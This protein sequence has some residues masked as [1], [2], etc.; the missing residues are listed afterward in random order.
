M[1][2]IPGWGMA[3]HSSILAWEIPWTEKP[4]RLQPMG[5]QRV[6]DDWAT[7]TFTFIVKSFILITSLKVYQIQS[8][9]EIWRLRL[10]Q[11]N[12]GTQFSLWPSSP[13]E[14]TIHRRKPWK[15]ATGCAKVASGCTEWQPIRAGAAE[16]SRIPGWPRTH[17]APATAGKASSQL[18]I[19]EF[20][21]LTPTLW[22]LSRCSK[23][24]ST[25]S[26]MVIWGGGSWG[27][28]CTLQGCER[29]D[30]ASCLALRRAWE[31]HQ[32]GR[33]DSCGWVGDELG[34]VGNSESN[35]LLFPPPSPP[36]GRKME[37][38]L[39]KASASERLGLF[40]L[41]ESLMTCL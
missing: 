5:L 16:T 17:L 26:G 28:P 22:E 30:P 20:S 36:L 4:D 33:T 23:H 27:L 25:T 13:W 15:P 24:F 21:A 11:L 9:Y 37:H 8:H 2:S 7:N 29:L 31:A 34:G 40:C 10:Q 12:V 19:F 35:L 1:G 38:L 32:V 14:E 3:T 6:R 18:G 39:L 41:K